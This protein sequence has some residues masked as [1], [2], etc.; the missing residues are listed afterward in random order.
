MLPFAGER[1]TIYRKRDQHTDY[2]IVSA[3]EAVGQNEYVSSYTCLSPLAP[4]PSKR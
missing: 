2:L 1:T 3:Y 4:S